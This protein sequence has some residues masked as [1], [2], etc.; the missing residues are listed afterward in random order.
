MQTI[1]IDCDGAKSAAEFWQRY[2]D[3]AKPEGA[4]LFGRN[5]DA[6]WDAIE[7]GGP[8]WPGEVKLVLRNSSELAALEVGSGLSLLDGLRR[9]ANEATQTSIELA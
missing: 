3:A 9:I 8:G 5:L 4:S 6:F 2:I 1:V 7:H